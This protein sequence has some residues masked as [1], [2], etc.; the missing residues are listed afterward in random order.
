MNENI[1]L[2][3]VH[4][5]NNNMYSSNQKDKVS[6]GK[7]SMYN[8]SLHKN[9]LTNNIILLKTFKINDEYIRQINE[10]FVQKL[11]KYQVKLYSA[12]TWYQN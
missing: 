12:K 5:W 6:Y 7:S 3:K 8:V 2:K 10:K 1:G 11:V 4:K 9:P